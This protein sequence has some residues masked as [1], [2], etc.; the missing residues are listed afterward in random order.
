MAGADYVLAVKENQPTLYAG[1]QQV[2]LGGLEEDFAGTEHRYR[3]TLDLGQGR[4]EERHYHQAGW[5]DD[6]LVQ[7]LLGQP[8]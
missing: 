4:T 1:V 7:V 3:H 5:D 2:L 8:Q 6:F